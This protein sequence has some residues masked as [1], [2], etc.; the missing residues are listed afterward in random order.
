M[1]RK[2]DRED[3]LLERLQEENRTLKQINRSL[4]KQVKK[5]NRGYL[6]F[7]EAETKEEE[8]EAIKEAKEV[9]KKIC[10]DCGTGE[11]KEIIIMNR[12]FRKCQDCGK[13]GKV[14]ILP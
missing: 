6:K 3:R 1:S 4:M 10:W 13:Q 11:Y 7:T 12:R 2:S 9:A 14:T 5:L 8:K